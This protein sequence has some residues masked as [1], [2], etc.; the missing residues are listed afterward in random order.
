MDGVLHRAYVPK[1]REVSVQV[2]H[3]RSRRARGG[4]VSRLSTQAPGEVEQSCSM[5]KYFS[6][7]DVDWAVLLIVLLI[8]SVGVLQIYSAARDTDNTSAWWK[9]ILYVGGGLMLM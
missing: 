6:P 4:A 1:R 3:S 8:C 2:H 5:A 7:R 9:Q